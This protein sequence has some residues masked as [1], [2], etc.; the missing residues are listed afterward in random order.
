[1]SLIYNQTTGELKDGETLLG[2]GWAGRGEGKNN[3]DMQFVRETGPLPQGFYTIESPVTHPR[4]GPLAFH[5]RPDPEN[6]MHGRDAFFI[7]GPSKSHYG[8]ESKGCIIQLRAVRI[9]LERYVG[10]KLQVI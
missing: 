1:M 2:I 9:Q 7:H 8:Q 3:P 5:L 4:L 6:E 10:Q